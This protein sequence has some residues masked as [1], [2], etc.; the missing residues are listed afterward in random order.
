MLLLVCRCSTWNV[1]CECI[2][3]WVLYYKYIDQI[4]LFLSHFLRLLL[5]ILLSRATC[6]LGI[7]CS[8]RNDTGYTMTLA[9]TT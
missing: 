2:P 9:K 8:R 4:F 5:E 3:S 7:F 1:K 6:T